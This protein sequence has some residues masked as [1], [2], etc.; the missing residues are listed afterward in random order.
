MPA[1]G[2]R[3]GGQNVLS[4]GRIG[5]GNSVT[6]QIHALIS[7]VENLDLECRIEAGIDLV[8]DHSRQLDRWKRRDG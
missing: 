1:R 8:E 3:L 2:Q 4:G 6:R 7:L 5:N